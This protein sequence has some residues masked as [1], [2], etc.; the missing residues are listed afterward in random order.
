VAKLMPPLVVTEAETQRGLAIL[1]QCAH[2]VLRERTES[3]E[4]P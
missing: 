1:R 4:N 2:E 3:R